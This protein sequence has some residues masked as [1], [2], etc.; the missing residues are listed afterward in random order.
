MTLGDR[1]VVM[2]GGAV[3][4]CGPPSEIY[5]RPS[6]RFVAGFVGTPSMNFLHGTM[7]R[8]GTATTF[9]SPLGKLILPER[10]VAHGEGSVVLGIRPQ[11]VRITGPTDGPTRTGLPSSPANWAVLAE[12]SVHMVEP[13][14]GSTDVHLTGSRGDRIV[15]RLRGT[16]KLSLADRVEVQVDVSAA[17]LFSPDD[18]GR[19]LN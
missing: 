13:L 12:M 3:Q 15:A 18:G 4:Q 7:A 1:I 17:H 8:D 2:N 9:E 19:R 11:D 10:V 6:N 14:G 5:Q 16:T